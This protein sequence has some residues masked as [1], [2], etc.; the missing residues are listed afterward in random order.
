[1]E[2]AAP[3]KWHIQGDFFGNC[4]CEYLRCPCPISNFT[5]MP[6]Q[7]FCKICIVFDVE[8]GHFNDTS[9]GG[10][11]VALVVD[12]P[13][14]MG[15]GNWALGVIMSDNATPDQQGALGAILGG[16]VGGPMELA[17]G[18]VTKF[19]GMEVR[20][21]KIEKTDK[22]FSIYVPD[23]IDYVVEKT[24]GLNPDEPIYL[25]NTIHPAGTRFALGRGKR[26]YMHAFGVDFEGIDDRQNG[27]FTK[28]NWS[29][30]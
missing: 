19:L 3:V 28:F 2:A 16:Q 27:V 9:L 14:I 7:G 30:N 8:E 18:W 6:T 26:S 29:V 5:E 21:M 11:T 12:V 17:A 25:D 22:T 23:M 1:M 24:V 13:G 15:D 4:S 20:P 10:V